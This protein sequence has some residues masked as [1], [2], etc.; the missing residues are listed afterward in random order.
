M[1]LASVFDMISM[2]ESSAFLLKNIIQGSI[3][4]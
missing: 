3:L 4:G 2:I 1:L